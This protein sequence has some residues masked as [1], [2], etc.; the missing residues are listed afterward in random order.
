MSFLNKTGLARLWANILA[1]VN[2]KVDKVEGKGL[3]TNDFTNTYKDK[4]DELADFSGNYDDLNGRPSIIDSLD[5]TSTTD[6]LS[7][8]QGKALKKAIDSI[9]GDIGDL[10]GG[11]MMKAAYD[12]DNDGIIDNSSRLEGHAASYFA[13]AEHTHDQY[14]TEETD[15]TVPDHV[16]QI[17]TTDI[18]NWNKK[19][20][21]DGNYDNLT[22][23]PTIPSKTSDLTNDVGFITQEDISSFGNGDM[24]K[25][26]YDQDNDGK[27]DVAK[28]ADYLG[29]I[30][31]DKYAKIA[32][33]PNKLADLTDDAT[34]R[35]VT[36]TEKAA[37]NEKVTQVP[38]KQ[39]STNDFTDE[40]K[41]KLDNINEGGGGIVTEEDPTVPAWAKNPTKPAYTAQ[42]V[43]AL[44][45]N[46]PLFSGDYND[47]DNAPDITEDESG[48]FV[49]TDPNGNIIFRSDAEGIETVKLFV[50]QLF[51]NGSEVLSFDDSTTFIID[52]NL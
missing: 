38:G 35:T 2:S 6:A 4:L 28:N 32:E 41:T 33:V 3:S 14:L 52:A 47:L 20:D 11:D 13:T 30:E 22:N 1:L 23:K 45:E 43:G 44:P 49:I 29:G 9:S 37:W 25:A 26:I 12:T 31:A 16:K 17:T 36:D 15:P 39:L 19:S 50:Q 7:A 46:T 8:A 51:I 34:H 48:E 40:Y 27:V 18:T 5:S 42:E 24:L 21:F 10:G